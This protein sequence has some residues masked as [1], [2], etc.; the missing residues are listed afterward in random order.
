MAILDEQ[1]FA[2]FYEYD[3]EGQLARI[4][5]ET[6]RGIGTIREIRGA[7]FKQAK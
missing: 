7:K 6:E 4:K 2:Y 3:A 1:N 5:K